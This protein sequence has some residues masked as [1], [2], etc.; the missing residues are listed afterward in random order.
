MTACLTSMGHFFPE[1]VLDNAFFDSLDIGSSS[2]WIEQRVGIKERRS[3]IK[4]EDI[5]KLKSGLTSFTKLL[6]EGGLPTIAEISKLTFKS[7]QERFSRLAC[8]DLDPN[9]IEYILC[10]S[11]T[12]D[13]EAP[14][15]ACS[16]ADSLGIKAVGLDINSACSTFIA[17]LHTARSFIESGVCSCIS[18]FTVDRYT[19]RIDYNDRSNCIL[20]GDSASSSL[21]QKDAPYGFKILD[22]FM[23]S[24]PSGYRSVMVPY[25]GKLYQDGKVV[26]KFAI[27]K[28]IEMC[29]LMLQRNSLTIDDLNY[30]IAHQANY[31]MLNSIVTKLGIPPEK[32]LYN[33]VTRG[34]QAASGAATC[35]SSN[36][37]RFISKDKVMVVVVGSGLSWGGL[38][39][40]K[41]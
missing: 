40:E 39:L 4:K 28:T 41:I 36:W 15:S 25:R 32:H 5:L 13:F 20:F 21:I 1:T 24:D 3:F 35:L 38:L 8:H 14:A 12:F 33:V 6:E 27:T 31:R 26:Q 19:A 34:N 17:L 22:S 23:E 11:G 29:K 7:L 37:D 10:G 30:F 18:C 2:E 16:I 9:I